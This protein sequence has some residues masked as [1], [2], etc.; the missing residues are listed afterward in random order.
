[1]ICWPRP[2]LCR[3][4]TARRKNPGAE[5]EEYLSSLPSGLCCTI[6]IGLLIAVACALSVHSRVVANY[7]AQSRAEF[8]SRILHAG[9]LVGPP[10]RCMRRC[11]DVRAEGLRFAILRCNQ[12]TQRSI[13]HVRQPTCRAHA[14]V[15]SSTLRSP[16]ARM[17]QISWTAA[18][19]VRVACTRPWSWAPGIA[20][21]MKVSQARAMCLHLKRD[22]TIQERVV[23]GRLRLR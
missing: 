2:L 8:V 7:R 12:S 21:A 18:V 4:P 13:R 19:M 20:Y 22:P 10:G 15:S 14:L 1:M 16:R 6:F 9:T 17:T 5:A 23:P 11:T 3:A